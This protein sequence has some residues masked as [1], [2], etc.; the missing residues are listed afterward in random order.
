MLSSLQD[1]NWCLEAG[2][3]RQAKVTQLPPSTSTHTHTH[4][5][6]HLYSDW[7]YTCLSGWDICSCRAA[8][9]LTTLEWNMSPAACGTRVRAIKED[10][11]GLSFPRFI[12]H[13]FASLFTT[14]ILCQAHSFDHNLMESGSSRGV[15][16]APSAPA[17]PPGNKNPTKL[18]Q[19]NSVHFFSSLKLSLH[20]D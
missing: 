2:G 15:Q 19:P 20:G 4:R 18:S 5:C 3:L 16:T 9:L 11:N 10:W 6:A 13:L 14:K 12:N 1:N 8:P 17:S 7:L